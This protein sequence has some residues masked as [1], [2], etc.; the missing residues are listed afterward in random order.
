[1]LCHRVKVMPFQTFRLNPLDCQPFNADQKFH[2]GQQQA[3][4][5]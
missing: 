5:Y 3:A 1:M 4:A 2:Q